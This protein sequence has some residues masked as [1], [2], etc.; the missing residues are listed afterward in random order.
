MLRPSTA[1][2]L[3]FQDAKHSSASTACG[4]CPRHWNT[5]KPL[6]RISTG[7]K[8]AWD[9]QMILHLLL[10]VRNNARGKFLNKN[11]LLNRSSTHWHGVRSSVRFRLWVKIAVRIMSEWQLSSG[12]K[13]AEGI[14]TSAPHWTNNGRPALSS[15]VM[16]IWGLNNSQ[17]SQVLV[18][19]VTS[20]D[21][22]ARMG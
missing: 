8:S 11:N 12:A 3:K 18:A 21:N 13:H 16:P 17:G 5:L 9:H 15:Q 2:G 4:K 14:D 22:P 20:F 19:V 6:S 10:S 1:T 7:K